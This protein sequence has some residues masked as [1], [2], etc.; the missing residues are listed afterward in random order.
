VRGARR[1]V[2]PFHDN[3]LG[4]QASYADDIDC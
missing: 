3:P 1:A 4:V 2:Y